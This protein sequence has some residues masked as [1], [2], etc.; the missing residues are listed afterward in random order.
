MFGMEIGS[1]TCT[2]GLDGFPADDG[3][4]YRAGL[5]FD[6]SQQVMLASR[7]KRGASNYRLLESKE[8]PEFIE[9]HALF[10]GHKFK[11][12]SSE[13]IQRL[14]GGYMPAK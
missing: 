6:G 2:V 5:V 1:A 4:E 14:T 3:Y 10:K 7:R 12:A 8:I 13:D 11:K 9:K